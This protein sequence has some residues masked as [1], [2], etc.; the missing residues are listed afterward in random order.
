MQRL[1]KP[2]RV[3]DGIHQPQGASPMVPEL[4]FGCWFG[5]LERLFLR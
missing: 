3:P 5:G 4:L 1:I 2:V